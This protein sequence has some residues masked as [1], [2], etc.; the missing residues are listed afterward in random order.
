ML[1][2][3][4]SIK[5]TKRL[6]DQEVHFA[7]FDVDQNLCTYRIDGTTQTTFY[8]VLLNGDI[9]FQ[10]DILTCQDGAL[11][12][13]ISTLKG[14]ASLSGVPLIGTHSPFEGQW[15]LFIINDD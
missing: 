11:L 10:G 4:I 5:P 15:S 9:A 8:V 14:V 6:Q 13:K 2:P 7:S 3:I 1:D 12:G